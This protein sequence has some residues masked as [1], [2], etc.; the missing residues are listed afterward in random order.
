MANYKKS[1]LVDKMVELSIDLATEKDDQTI[2]LTKKQAG[3][4]VSLFAE[5][6]R[7]LIKEEGDKLGIVNLFTVEKYMAKPRKV[8]DLQNGGVREIPARVRTRIKPKF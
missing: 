7:E 6:I 2:K 3:Y 8:N 1:D 5:A 4:A